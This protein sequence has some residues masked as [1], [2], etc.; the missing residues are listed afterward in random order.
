MVQV[1]LTLAAVALFIFSPGVHR[2]RSTIRDTDNHPVHVYGLR[3]AFAHDHI[4]KLLLVHGMGPSAPGSTKSFTDAIGSRLGFGAPGPDVPGRLA[5]PLSLPAHAAPAVLR[6]RTYHKKNTDGS[7]DALIIYELTWSPLITTLKQDALGYESEYAAARVRGNAYLKAFLM[8][9]RLT[10]PVLY[11]G[12]MG[13]YI[14]NAV[15][16]AACTMVNGVFT[17]DLVPLG[18]E[19][20]THVHD[21]HMSVAIITQSL[22]SRITYDALSELLAQPTESVSA[23]QVVLQHTF[24][25]YLLA[26]QL[27]LLG[28]ATVPTDMPPGFTLE[29]SSLHTLLVLRKRVGPQTPL[30]FTVIAVSDPNDLL[31]YPIPKAFADPEKG[32]EYRFVNVITGIGRKY[33]NGLVAN[34]LQAHT[35]HTSNPFVLDLIAY[36]HDGQ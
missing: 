18:S 27:P 10:D 33:A 32:P 30:P 1:L 20:C 34:P 15:K 2:T 8:N 28:L 9:E 25:I 24:N 4:V 29:R 13:P 16:H 31:S 6:L 5:A 3:D 21:D 36:G 23:P 11:I 12:T 7:T 17:Q 26:N 22:G 14:R 19:T 35:G